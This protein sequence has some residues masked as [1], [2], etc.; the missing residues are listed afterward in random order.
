MTFTV[1]EISTTDHDATNPMAAGVA[2]YRIREEGDDPERVFAREV[3]RLAPYICERRYLPPR[4]MGAEQFE[5]LCRDP[6]G[7]WKFP[8]E[9]AG[10]MTFS[11]WIKLQWRV[12][13]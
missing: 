4:L 8:V 3:A 5:D 13:E 7:W 2:M 1:P 10:R 6:I 11:D 9:A 12:L